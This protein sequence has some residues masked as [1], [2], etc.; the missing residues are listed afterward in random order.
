MAATVL[1]SPG[2]VVNSAASFSLLDA[3]IRN[4]RQVN[5]NSFSAM[6]TPAADWGYM[7]LVAS[8]NTTVK[9]TAGQLHSLIV[10]T[11]TGNISIYDGA[12]ANGN[13]ILATCALF[14]AGVYVFDVSFA[15]GLFI[16]LSGAGVAS[17]TFR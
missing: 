13:T 6:T 4:Y 5:D 10:G 14:A 15:T 12:S 9:T 1:A 3:Q 7:P 11:A 8:G 16:V 17:V 2:S